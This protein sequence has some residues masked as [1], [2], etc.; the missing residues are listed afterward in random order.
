MSGLLDALVTS[1]GRLVTGD[2]VITART[3]AAGRT[4]ADL[5]S[6]ES[7]PDLS[8]DQIAHVLRAIPVDACEAGQVPSTL[9][10]A[11]AHLLLP[12]RLPRGLYRADGS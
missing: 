6:P 7:H 11:R 10:H 9:T 12:I 5:L 3:P 2:L 4:L 8:A 1:D